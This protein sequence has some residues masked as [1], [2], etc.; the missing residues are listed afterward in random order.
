RRVAIYM[1][2]GEPFPKVFTAPDIPIPP[3]ALMGWEIRA[4]ETSVCVSL[5]GGWPGGRDAVQLGGCLDGQRWPRGRLAGRTGAQLTRVPGIVP[6]RG[7]HGAQRR[8]K[9]ANLSRAFLQGRR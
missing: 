8:G 1:P 2:L 3:R 5:P 7:R 6:G 9:A 4:A